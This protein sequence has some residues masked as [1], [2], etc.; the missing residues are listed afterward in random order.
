LHAAI[1]PHLLLI[2][3][4]LMMDF[5]GQKLAERLSLYILLG[6]A[7]AAFLVGWISGHFRFTLLTYGAGTAAAVIAA[8]PDW[9][10]FNMHPLQWQE[11]QPAK[12]PPTQLPSASPVRRRARR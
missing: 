12:D 5:Q 3:Q 6:A 11:V 1:L 7:M 10:W 9:P 4:P 8:V 2:G